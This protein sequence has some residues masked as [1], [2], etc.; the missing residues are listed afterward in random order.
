MM[1]ASAHREVGGGIEN[2]LH[3]NDVDDQSNDNDTDEEE[4]V[5]GQSFNNART[6]IRKKVEARVLVKNTA[7][8]GDGKDQR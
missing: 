1:I 6:T 8:I 3:K 4:D 5:G 7:I 2:F